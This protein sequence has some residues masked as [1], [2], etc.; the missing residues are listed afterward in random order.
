HGME[1]AKRSI[2]L[3]INRAALNDNFAIF[4]YVDPASHIE[5]RPV[6]SVP[7][8]SLFFLNNELVW[9]SSEKLGSDLADLSQD[10]NQ[11]ILIAFK[12]VLGR[13]PSS[14]ELDR[15]K[16]FVVQAI[17]FWG[18]QIKPADGVDPQT[19]NKTLRSK[20]LGS[21]VHSLFSLREFIWV[22]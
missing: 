5:Q 1:S 14:G 17:E 12:R 15:S 21:L 13:E 6:T 18:V 22:E 3:N 4:D 2:Y 19:H 10:E 8:Q 9:K 20:A 11:A 7:S 16:T